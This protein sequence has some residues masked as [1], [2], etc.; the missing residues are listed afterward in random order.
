M[1]ASRKQLSKEETP[2]LNQLLLSSQQQGTSQDSSSRQRQERLHH[3]SRVDRNWP[4]HP[5]LQDRRKHHHQQLLLHPHRG[6]EQ[7][8][9]S[10]WD[11]RVQ[12]S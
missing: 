8:E 11:L 12:L 6:H 2:L 5:Q 3:S 10:Q 7:L 4:S 1:T 9:A